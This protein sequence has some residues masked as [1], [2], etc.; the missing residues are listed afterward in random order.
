MATTHDAS[1]PTAAELIGAT[2][3]FHRRLRSRLIE[4]L[5]LVDLTYAQFEV[6]EI[7]E[8]DSNHHAGSLAGLLAVTRQ[9]A[10]RI[11]LRMQA[12]GLVR[13]EA[14]DGGVKPIRITGRGRRRLAETRD[15]LEGLHRLI[16]DRLDP[17]TRG[18]LVRALKVAEAAIRPPPWF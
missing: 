7:I 5:D 13:F 11:A 1:A 4:A 18:T 2:R 9:A 10:H 6:L 15:H 8:H 12:A 3:H 17:E 16:D 14:P